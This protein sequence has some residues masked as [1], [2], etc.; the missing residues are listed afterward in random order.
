MIKHFI[1]NTVFMLVDSFLLFGIKFERYNKSMMYGTGKPSAPLCA[2]TI[3]AIVITIGVNIAEAVIL[4]KQQKLT[5]PYVTVSLI[6]LV[7]PFI[8]YKIA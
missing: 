4:K 5:V 2:A 1:L 7:I 6:L 3:C 8:I